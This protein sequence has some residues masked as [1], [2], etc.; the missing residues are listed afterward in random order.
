MEAR[1]IITFQQNESGIA[2]MTDPFVRVTIIKGVVYETNYNY[3]Y[4]I[5]II[6]HIISKFNNYY[7][8]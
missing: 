7:N 2:V 6:E 1:L 3:N 5:I 8:S 4:G